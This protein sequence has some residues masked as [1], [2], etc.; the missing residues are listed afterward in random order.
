M[1]D[2]TLSLEARVLLNLKRNRRIPGSALWVH[3]GVAAPWSSAACPHG[4][5][6]G[7]LRATLYLEGSACES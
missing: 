7:K 5:P 6:P 3:L 4:E 2:F 1:Q